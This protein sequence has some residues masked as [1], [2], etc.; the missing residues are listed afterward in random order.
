MKKHALIRKH[1]SRMPI[2][3]SVL[4]LAFIFSGLTGAEGKVNLNAQASRAN[5][6]GTYDVAGTNED[7]S[8]YRGEL[9]ILKQGSVYQFR[10]A[11]GIQYDGVGV[12][13]GDTI[14]VAY[15]EGKTGTG[16]GV[17][18][19][20]ILQGGTLDGI[21]G[22]WGVNQSGTE[23]AARVGSVGLAGSYNATGT[24]PDGTAYKASITIAAE[25]S[26][27][28]FNW[29]NGTSGF[30]V[31]QGNTLSVGYGGSQCSWVAYEIRPNGVLDGIWGSYGSSNTGTEK[32]TRK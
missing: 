15:T 25:G 30:G 24:N 20:R 23:R 29:S 17:V 19:Y 8:T 13:N 10:W 16:C 14:A 4:L 5:I 28:K 26:G 3:L 9:R 7:G 2:A 27:Y 12:I 6:P 1:T 21:W 31:K 22:M 32:A 18:S 11:T